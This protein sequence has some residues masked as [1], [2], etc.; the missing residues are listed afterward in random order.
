MFN[1]HCMGKALICIKPKQCLFFTLFIRPKSALL[2]LLG[3]WLKRRHAFISLILIWLYASFWAT[4]PLVGVGNY[5]PE[6]FGTSCTLDWWLAQAS[7]TGKVFVIS[8][9]FFCL[10]LPTVVIVFSYAKIIAKVKSSAQEVAV[11]DTRNQKNH[12]LEIKLT[13]VTNWP[14]SNIDLWYAVALLSALDVPKT[15]I[16]PKFGVRKCP[17]AASGLTDL[18]CAKYMRPKGCGRPL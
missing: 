14:G 15:I 8:I 4:L 5:A 17:V 1:C 16:L 10:I 3:T 11:F 9:F 13:K 6:P 12:T 2:F 7:V 18:K